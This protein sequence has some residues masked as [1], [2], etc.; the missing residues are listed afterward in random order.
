MQDEARGFPLWSTFQGL[1]TS[2]CLDDGKV[3]D[4][5][6][7]PTFKDLPKKLAAEVYAINAMESNLM[8]NLNDIKQMFIGE[9]TSPDNAG[10]DENIGKKREL[11]DI[12]N[13]IDIFEGRIKKN[14]EDEII[15]EEDK[16]IS[17]DDDNSRDNLLAAISILEDEIKAYM[18]SK[19]QLLQEMKEATRN[20]KSSLNTA[21]KNIRCY[22]SSSDSDSSD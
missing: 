2:A 1:P 7:S 14:E 9:D 19:D 4:E 3:P 20:S 12:L 11:V 10:G 17:H 21:K 18:D 13:D 8:T 6:T 16:K 5:D 22:L 15:G